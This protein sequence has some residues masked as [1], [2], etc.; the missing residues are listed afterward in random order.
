MT[1]VFLCT[2][3]ITV[4]GSAMRGIVLFSYPFL[5]ERRM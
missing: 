5:K 2:S 4:D 3:Y 1:V